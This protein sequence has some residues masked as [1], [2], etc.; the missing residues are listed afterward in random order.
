M[1]NLETLTSQFVQLM[2]KNCQDACIRQVGVVTKMITKSELSGLLQFV[3][4]GIPMLLND[5]KYA[6]TSIFTWEKIIA[7][8]W[9]ARK[10]YCV[11]TF[12]CRVP[13]DLAFAFGLFFTDG[14]LTLGKGG[15][16]AGASWRIVNAN[17][18]Y[19]KRA[20]NALDW[21]Y[22]DYGLDFTITNYE[23]YEKGQ[24]TNY[25]DRKKTLYCLEPKIRRKEGVKYQG[26]RGNFIK[27]WQHLCYDPMVGKK[28]IP[29]PIF[30]KE[31]HEPK[32]AFL[33]GV[34]AG[35]G[36]Q[37]PK[38]QSRYISM[39]TNN[40]VACDHLDSILWMGNWNYHIKRLPKEWRF[41]VKEQREPVPVLCDNFSDA[42]RAHAAEIYNLKSA[43]AFH[44]IVQADNGTVN[45]TG[46]RAVL[47]CALDE[48]N[49]LAL[50]VMES[51]TGAIGR[52][53]KGQPIKLP[54]FG[55]TWNYSASD[56][57]WN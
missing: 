29:K 11:D 31:H 26:N 55:T 46:H 28:W 19:L 20:K 50:Y 24:K 47:I 13:D 34:Y 41:Y 35:N 17:L 14:S 22:K 45:K 40:R 15:K 7:L 30:D 5:E 25:G 48:S 43:G 8:D 6:V 52:I 10:K 1:N 3:L 9:T 57:S 38:G 32:K 44:C 56:S 54:V 36:L 21:E 23:S 33:E 12:D 37:N 39:G 16:S 51:E 18:D 42:F 27:F 2:V 53:T 49:Q 4:P